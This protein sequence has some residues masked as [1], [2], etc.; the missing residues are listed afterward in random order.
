MI[1]EYEALLEIVK[2]KNK[3]QGEKCMICYFPDIQS[4]LVKLD[5][6]HFFHK[7]C[8]F[9]KDFK[10]KKVIKCPYCDSVTKF[11]KDYFNSILMS[12]KSK[13]KVCNRVNCKIEQDNKDENI[14]KVILKSGLN[15]GKPCGRI[16]CKYHNKNIIV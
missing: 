10:Y 8:I 7:K 5:C 1:S 15:K 2:K 6:G 11:E 14:C 3:V 13:D 4:K 9:E 12:G 16:N